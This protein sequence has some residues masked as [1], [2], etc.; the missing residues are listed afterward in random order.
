M[1]R[2][3]ALFAL[4]IA[5]FVVAPASAAQAAPNPGNGTFKII[6]KRSG[7]CLNQDY[8]GGKPHPNVLAWKCTVGTGAWNEIWEITTASADRLLIKNKASGKCLN[9]DFSGNVE[10]PGVIVYTCNWDHYNGVWLPETHNGVW[11]FSNYATLKCL[12]QDYTGGVARHEV[13][14]WTCLGTPHA[15]NNDWTLQRAG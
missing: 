12:N 11:E 9:Q 13:L 6:N 2:L 14:A 5:A 10:H 7:M 8:S 15:T 4:M 3:L 1:R